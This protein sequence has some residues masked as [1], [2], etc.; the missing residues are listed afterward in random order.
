MSD[1]RISRLMARF[2]ETAQEE[3]TAAA[4]RRAQ[5]PIPPL[6]QSRGAD[7][8]AGAPNSPNGQVDKREDEEG[9]N[10]ESN[11]DPPPP[12]NITE[13]IVAPSSRSMWIIT[14][15]YKQRVYLT[16]SRCLFV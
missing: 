10:M 8:S 6:E 7:L 4:P 9:G 3:A 12:P 5:V 16:I 2:E 13:S 15:T 14:Q 1:Q 11:A